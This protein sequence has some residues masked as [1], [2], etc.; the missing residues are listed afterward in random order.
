M[1]HKDAMQILPETEVF[2]TWNRVEGLR[3]GVEGQE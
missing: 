3:A 2:V 1:Y